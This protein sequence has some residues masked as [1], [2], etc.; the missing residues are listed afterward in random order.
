MPVTTACVFPFA[1]FCSAPSDIVELGSQLYLDACTLAIGGLSWVAPDAIIQRAMRHT[2][3]ETKRRY[4]LGMV[5]KVREAMEKANQQV[6]GESIT[7]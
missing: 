1:A 4:Q 5:E 3:P 7:V 6:Y 2:S